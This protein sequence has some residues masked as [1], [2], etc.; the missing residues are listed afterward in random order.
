MLALLAGCYMGGV[1]ITL[2]LYKNSGL[3]VKSFLISGKNR[4]PLTVCRII[5]QGRQAFEDDRDK[6]KNFVEGTR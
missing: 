3:K 1:L 5:S 6:L 2:S 4:R